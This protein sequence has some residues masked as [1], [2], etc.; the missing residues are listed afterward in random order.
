MFNPNYSLF[1]L[2][3]SGATYYPNPKSHIFGG[4]HLN[5]FKFVGRIIGK[6]IFDECLLECYFVKA[7]YKIISGEELSI[8]DLEDFDNEYYNNLKW[9]LENDVA[10]LMTTMSVEQ[11]YYGKIEEI[12]LVPGGKTIPLT[13][14]NKWTYVEKIA[15]FRLYKSTAQ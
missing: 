13:N 10:C 5:Y 2:S 7:L 3:S 12:E 8:K 9:C 4:D 6:A 14:D 1:S 15:H 11:D